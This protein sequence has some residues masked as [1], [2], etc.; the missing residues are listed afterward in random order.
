MTHNHSDPDSTYP[1]HGPEAAT[2]H[3][4]YAYLRLVRDVIARGEHRDDRTGTGTLSLFGTQS[5]VS[6]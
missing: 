4:E 3:P 5:L 6:A 2:A 1:E